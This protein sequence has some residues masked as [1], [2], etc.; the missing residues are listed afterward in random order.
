MSNNPIDSKWLLEELHLKL[1]YILP[2]WCSWK[3]ITKEERKKKGD[4]INVLFRISFGGPVVKTLCIQGHRFNLRMEIPYVT[5]H[6]ENKWINKIMLSLSQNYFR[7]VILCDD[8]SSCLAY[9]T[10]H[11]I[12]GCNVER[13]WNY[14]RFLRLQG[15]KKWAHTMKTLLDIPAGPANK[16]QWQLSQFFWT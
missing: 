13:H 9:E 10:L 7:R 2:Q 16:E 12:Q 6:S 4:F 3:H 15:G 11:T 8:D 1:L 14:G 5:W